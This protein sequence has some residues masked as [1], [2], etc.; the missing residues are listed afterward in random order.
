MKRFLSFLL[1]FVGLMCLA[2]KSNAVVGSS[3]SA[4]NVDSLGDVGENLFQNYDGKVAPVALAYVDFKIDRARTA[5]Q[6]GKDIGK[7]NFKLFGCRR[8]DKKI[9]LNQG[10]AMRRDMHF[11][12]V[13]FE[14]L[15]E[16]IPVVIPKDSKYYPYSVGDVPAGYLLTAEIK[17]LYVN[18]CDHYDWR[19]RVYSNMRSGTAEIKVKWRIMT[20]YNHKVYWEGETVGYSQIDDPIR[21][22]EVRLIEKAF[23][24]ALVR[25][26]GSSMDVLHNKPDLEALAKAKAEHDA[27]AYEHLLKRQDLQS[28]YRRKRQR[29]YNER[30]R[31]RELQ[32]LERLEP[33]EK[34]FDD[35]IGTD[36][37][38]KLL[39]GIGKFDNGDDL[40][41]SLDKEGKDAS[42][43]GAMGN[44]NSDKERDLDGSEGG[45]F[46]RLFGEGGN[47]IAGKLMLGDMENGTLGRLLT[48]NLVGLFDGT[49]LDGLDKETQDAITQ[50]DFDKFG[51][52]ISPIDSWITIN[53]IKPFKKLTPLRMYR[54][55]SSVVAVISGD[56]SVGS[57]LV[58]APGLVLTNYETIK[59]S[60][61]AGIEFLDGRM[62][63]GVVLRVNKEKDVALVY[64][65][66][67][68]FDKYNW[69][70]PLRI[71]L[72]EVGEPFY[73]IG[74]PMRGGLEGAIDHGKV[75]GYR[76]IDNGVDILT[77]T[78]LQ[79]VSL[80]GTLVD[81]KG[82]AI[83]ISYGGDKLTDQVRDKFIPIGDAFQAL[84]VKILDRD[85]DESPTDKAN[86]LR[87]Q[88][89]DYIK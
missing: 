25:M 81:E 65:R 50:G 37:S 1:F 60:P 15:N 21:R 33:E 52:S 48:M 84:K 22:G 63:D 43:L 17:D 51:F 70:L 55:R 56:D 9:V 16:L 69:P 42:K 66:P 67:D 4:V 76:Y 8:V 19:T 2:E 39:G 80:G 13:F 73:A 82:N 35:F 24:D 18:A 36:M 45:I 23:G 72:P 30:I 11:N 83:G 74:T 64:M 89:E 44:G 87:K 88:R 62:S 59:H 3:E 28:S 79:S 6:Y 12:D 46:G 53:N 75:A 20:P 71:D 32:A 29:F 38:G 57:G 7:Y 85:M 47:G 14:E 58:I 26:V 31:Q 78:N 54:I 40:A 27:L 5:N 61:F 41:G 34:E 49:G 10:R 77:N 68:G 86:L